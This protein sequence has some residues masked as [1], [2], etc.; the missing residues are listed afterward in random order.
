MPNAFTP[1][2]DA[3]NE[4]FKGKGFTVGMNNFNMSIWNRWG[5]LLFNT[6]NVDSGWNGL[7]NNTGSPAPE[8]VYIYEV[9]YKNPDGNL[10]RIKGYVTLTR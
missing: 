2:D 6:N 8:G 1:N 9:S 10:Q 4:E 7:K 3:I 5:E